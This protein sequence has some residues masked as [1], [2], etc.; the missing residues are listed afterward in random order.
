MYLTVCSTLFTRSMVDGVCTGKCM[1]NN[2]LL[3]AK[4]SDN[5]FK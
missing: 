1:E 3:D 2:S 5:L 4:D